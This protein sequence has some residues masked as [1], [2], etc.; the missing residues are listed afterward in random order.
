MP[1]QWMNVSQH[2]LNKASYKTQRGGIQEI[3][4]DSWASF[5]LDLRFQT[6]WP[7][8]SWVCINELY[9]L[10]GD[11]DKVKGQAL[12]R[13]QSI[14]LLFLLLYRLWAVDD[15]YTHLNM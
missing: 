9:L 2:S 15:I 5:A 14:G 10:T 6:H 3:P 12:S 11:L 4:M 13:S 8:R 1:F 7:T